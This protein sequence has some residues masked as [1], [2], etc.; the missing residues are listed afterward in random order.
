[1]EPADLS[2]VLAAADGTPRVHFNPRLPPDRQ[3][4]DALLQWLRD[5]PEAHGHHLFQTSGTTT[6]AA[7][8]SPGAARWV[9][10]SGP[11]LQASA[12][13]VNHHLG[14]GPGDAW[15]LALPT[16]HVGGFGVLQR[17]ALADI[18]VF[19]TDPRWQAE[20]F[21][22]SARA[23]DATLSA[24]V[25]AQVC[26]LV[27]AKLPAPPTLRA[28]LVGG[29]R[30]D[31]ALHRR[32]RQLG[33]PLLRTFGMTETAS[34]IAT[35]H[36]PAPPSAADHDSARTAPWLP[37]L[38]AWQLRL[39]RNDVPPLTA[40]DAA[41]A[42]SLEIR[43]PA[44]FSGYVEADPEAPGWRWIDPRRDG[45]WRCRDL[46]RLRPDANPDPSPEP[47]TATAATSGQQLLWCG[48]LDRV[49]KVLG[50]LVDLDRVEAVLQDGART[51]I[52]PG[53]HPPPA[54]VA[55]IRRT[56]PRAGDLPVLVVSGQITTDQARR[57]LERV[58]GRLAP[59]EQ[60]RALW[61]IDDLPLS[62]LGKVRYRELEQRLA[63]EIAAAACRADPEDSPDQP[64]P[65]LEPVIPFRATGRP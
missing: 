62:P 9:A 33:W 59:F 39:H 3:P 20:N 52:R 36:Q 45:W 23:S 2:H 1:M 42:G 49:I 53:S 16:F 54:W 15:L 35:E 5:R 32:A 63:G 12:R 40:T 46:V 51:V 10:L 26:D 65:P 21:V 56:D 37:V 25:P 7:G 22:R 57:L 34:Q 41:T 4:P 50:E 43:G 6:A 38:A 47:T 55:V 64:P 13:A 28:V 29:G 30:L 61:R 8:R 27:A 44:L 31:P 11:A 17:A 19:L 48:R 14:T 60:P 24:L 58:A 18:P